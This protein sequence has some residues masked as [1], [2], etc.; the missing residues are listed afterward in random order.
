MKSEWREGTIGEVCVTVTDGSHTSP[1]S[2]DKGHYMVSVKDFTPFGFDFM[3]CRQISDSDY[4]LL[5]KNGCVPQINDILVGKDGARYFEDIILYRQPEKPALLSSIAIIRCNKQIIL[6]KFLYYILKSPDF[7]KDVRDNYGSGSAI[8]RI[9]LKDFKRM[10]IRYPNI[11]IQRSISDTLSCLDDKIELNNRINKNLEAQAQAIFKSWF[12]DF[13]PFQGGDF[14]DSEL[15]Q[16]PKG[17]SIEKVE[18]IFNI[19]IG[20]TP[21]RKE[22]EWFSKNVKDVKWLSIADMGKGNI[23]VIN[24]SEYLTHEAIRKFK[25]RLVP[26]NTILLSFKLT[27]GR[28]AISDEE[29]TTNEAIAHFNNDNAN[30]LP[31]TYF[32]LKQFDYSRLGNTSS[33]ATAVNSKTI[34]AM[35]FL[36]PTED[37][38]DNYYR[39]CNPI[40]EHIIANEVQNKT[41]STLRDT[42]LPKLMSGEIQIPQEV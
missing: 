22:H 13:E 27:I 29:M 35:P 34:R 32:Y 19:T 40:I 4:L 39:L 5:K 41:L 33:I 21:P 23:S 42:L 16:I 25:V 1:K 11:S 36:L 8:P 6:P 15:G 2:V 26:K 20:K 14:V 37:V 38:I 18:K 24:T 9:I 30:M 3:N 12:V 31:Y 17:W 7:K 10:P 28:V